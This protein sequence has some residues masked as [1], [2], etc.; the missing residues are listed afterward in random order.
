M[1]KIRVGYQ[2][3]ENSNNHRAAMKLSERFQSEYEVEL[4]PL[5]SSANVV[6]ALQ[7]GDVEYGVMAHSG[8]DGWL[9]PE[10][11]AACE[12]IELELIGQTCIEIHHFLYK[13]NSAV[14]FESLKKV[15]SHPAALLVCHNHIRELFPDIE[16]VEVEDTALSAKKLSEG[17]ISEDTAVICSEKAGQQY[18]LCLIKGQMQDRNPN[19]VNF[20]M[21]KL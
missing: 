14:P 11:K 6:K 19:G 10:T 8:T 20:I 4:I 2:G 12:G 5:I 18:N 1:E 7:Q 17:I 3:M 16:E 13:K 15:A 21:V 9:V